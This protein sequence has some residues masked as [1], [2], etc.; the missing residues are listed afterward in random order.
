MLYAL[1]QSPSSNWVQSNHASP[2]PPVRQRTVILAVPEGA[3]PLIQ[4]R[5]Q[6][7]VKLMELDVTVE[8]TLPP[9]FKKRMHTAA[10][11]VDALVFT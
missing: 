5:C 9:A 6:S 1:R 4:M 11:V 7:L 8:S 3:V 10:A 2:S